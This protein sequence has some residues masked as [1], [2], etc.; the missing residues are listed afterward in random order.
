M[1]K[2]AI[3]IDD[4]A[5]MIKTGFDGV[6]NQIGDLKQ[7]MN[8][9]F[10]QVEKHFEGVEKRLSGVEY[11]LDSLEDGMNRR[12]DAVDD[13]LEKVELKLD[14]VAYRFELRAL[15]QRVTFLERKAGVQ[16]GTV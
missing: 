7:D 12:F 6:D 4:L 5:T 2:R 13:R 8:T 3:T 10:A 16:T 1:E 9:R 11:K 14:N 15:E